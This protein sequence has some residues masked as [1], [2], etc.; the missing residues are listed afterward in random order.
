MLT[1]TI[2]YVGQVVCGIR[3]HELTRHFVTGRISLTCACGYESHG[4]ELGHTRFTDERFR[5]AATRSSM[6]PHLATPR[7]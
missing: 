7:V 5:E 2:S 4:W 3:G 1:D 6:K